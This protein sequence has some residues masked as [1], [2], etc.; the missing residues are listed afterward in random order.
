MSEL[1]VL[2][3][4]FALAAPTC[5][6]G[7]GVAEGPGVGVSVGPGVGVTVGVGVTETLGVGVGVHAVQV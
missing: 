5:V 2:A 7:V 4:L 1:P 3:R 6:P